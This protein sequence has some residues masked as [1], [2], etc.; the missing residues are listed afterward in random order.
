MSP[1]TTIALRRFCCAASLLLLPCGLLA[2]VEG[3]SSG[4]PPQLPPLILSP[5]DSATHVSHRP[6]VRW[7]SVDSAS[8]YLL[9]FVRDSAEGPR[10]S[11]DSVRLD[12]VARPRVLLEPEQ[13]YAWRLRAFNAA[14]AGPWSAPRLL[15]TSPLPRPET[16]ILLF[17]PTRRGKTS[18]LT[19]HLHGSAQDTLIVDSARTGTRAFRT[20]TTPD[21]TPGEGD[22]ILVTVEFQP[23]GFSPQ[24]DTL[25]LYTTEG[26]VSV[27]L[28]GKSP[29]PVLASRTRMLSFGPVAIEDT[30]TGYVAIRNEGKTNRL[31]IFNIFHFSGAFLSPG[32]GPFHVAP[33]ES[34]LVQVRFTAAG[35]RPKA[36]GV[37]VDT[38][39]IDSDGGV[40]KLPLRGDS[41]A[42]V[43]HVF[44]R[45]ISFGATGLSDS[46]LAVLRV[47]NSSV[48]ALEL[49]SLLLR[50]GAFAP[51]LGSALIRRG[52][53]LSIPLRFLPR[54]YGTHAD[55]LF[56]QG[57]FRAAI[58]RIPLAGTCPI[59]LLVPSPPELRFGVVEAHSQ[60]RQTLAIGN[61]S[62]SL[63]RV[64][65]L[66]TR[67]RLF[68]V[69]LLPEFS[70]VRMGDSLHVP[71]TFSPDTSGA[72]IDTLLVFNSSPSSPARIPLAGSA[73]PYAGVA[74][75]GNGLP[76]DFELGQNYPNPFNGMTTIRFGL[77]AQSQVRLYVYNAIGQELAL[78]AE[79]E[80][81]AGYH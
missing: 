58:N 63:L 40:L 55:T 42:P 54:R 27:L 74:G 19:F 80:L 62:S 53:T 16:R 17:P 4:A 50:S 43:M 14:G 32:P 51:L 61:A 66:K 21:P 29:P 39:V 24:T 3:D 31:T 22:T 69:S 52:D 15:M 2:Q 18:R 57:N 45:Q 60:I 6:L 44:P 7:Q 49:D 68:S 65:S 71:V 73:T 8:G 1:H 79:G 30:A 35:F 28:L 56:L 64:D 46:S 59:P 33:G 5:A 70:A 41:P 76:E 38:L 34:L 75:R 12:T 72:F 67:K 26:P 10:V 37:H 25:T 78:L 77:P 20:I 13:I 48:N 47:T 11:L 81:Q 23:D 9:E 36:Y